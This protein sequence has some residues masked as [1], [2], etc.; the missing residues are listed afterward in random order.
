M[1]PSKSPPVGETFKTYLLPM[2]T[3]DRIL[4][5]SAIGKDGSKGYIQIY[6]TGF[7]NVLTLFCQY[8]KSGQ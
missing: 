8:I 5:F 1:A 2:A 3:L 4:P 6:A 7:N